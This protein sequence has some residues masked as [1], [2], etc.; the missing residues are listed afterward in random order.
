[1]L[2]PPNGR[3]KGILERIVYRV[4]KGRGFLTDFL[5]AALNEL[6]EI[7]QV[8]WGRNLPGKTCAACFAPPALYKHLGLKQRRED[9]PVDA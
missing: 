4:M 3:R 1:M 9:C 7:Q 8:D 6:E 2:S 5:R